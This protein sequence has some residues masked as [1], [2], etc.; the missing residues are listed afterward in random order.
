MKDLISE[1]INKAM[2][3]LSGKEKE[4]LLQEALKNNSL[5][6]EEFLRKM[7]FDDYEIEQIMAK[8]AA[9]C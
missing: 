9:V 1:I 7:K 2:K 6:E 4:E 8:V 5:T 3:R